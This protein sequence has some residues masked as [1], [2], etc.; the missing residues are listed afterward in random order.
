MDALANVAAQFAIVGHVASIEPIVAGHINDTYL[1]TTDDSPRYVLQRINHRIFRDPPGLMRNVQLVTS[2]VR[3]KLAAA[4]V[5][6]LARRVLEVVP[7]RADEP[8]LQT[9]QGEFWRV[10]RFVEQTH[11]VPNNASL[12]EIYQAGLG[13][14]WFAAQLSDLPASSLIETIPRFHHGPRRYQAFLAAATADVAGRADSCR[15][16]MEAT[17]CYESLLLGP[18]RDIDA[19]RLPLRI[20]HNDT[21]CNNILLDDTTNEAMCVIDLDTVMPGLLMWDFGDLVRTSACRAAEDET[22]LALV[23]AEVPRVEAA[24]NGYRDGLGNLISGTELA[25][26]ASGPSYMALIMA[27]RFLTDY[28]QGDIYYKIHHP[29]HNLDRCRNQLK[30]VAEL[31]NERPRLEAIFGSR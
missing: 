29:A 2:H 28:L 25:S 18:Q 15:A 5:S 22:D 8:L 26:L 17:R 13:F 1:V 7:S 20:T 19:G 12:N 9:E 31:E 14:G 30:L 16:E 21:K 10:Y 11:P 4:G 27:T 24:A 3:S 6:D 23:K